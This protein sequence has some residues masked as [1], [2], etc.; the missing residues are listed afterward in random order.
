M[1]DVTNCSI[2]GKA[3]QPVMTDYFRSD[4]HLVNNKNSKLII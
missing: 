2:I 4:A 1:T 3:D